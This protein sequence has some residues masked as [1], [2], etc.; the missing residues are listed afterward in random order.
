[1]GEPEKPRPE[2]APNRLD[3]EGRKTGQWAEEDAHGGFVV[4]EYVAGQR[5]GI[6]RHYADDGRLRSE[7]GYAD[8][9]L[10]GQWTW[11]R[12]N[13]Q[14]LQRGDFDHEKRHGL[15][16]RWTAEGA[17]IDSGRYEQDEKVGEWHYY[18]PDGTIKKTTVHKP[19][20]Q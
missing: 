13:G 18:H 11:W 16:E 4:G 2:D 19:R 7:G 17:L 1:M 15:W 3:D 12:A 9:L 14:L 10:H 6:W 8:G 20:K 5:E